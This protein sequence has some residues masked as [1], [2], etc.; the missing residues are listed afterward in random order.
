MTIVKCLFAIITDLGET[1]TKWAPSKIMLKVYL[2]NLTTLKKLCGKYGPSS[3]FYLQWSQMYFNSQFVWTLTRERCN[4]VPHDRHLVKIPCTKKCYF[5]QFI[6]VSITETSVLYLKEGVLLHSQPK[7]RFRE[8]FV[9]F[10]MRQN[11]K[12]INHSEGAENIDFTY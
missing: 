2:K 7:V 12:K 11:L 5:L 6:V 3:N 1:A 9:Y 10:L 4:Q 8:Y